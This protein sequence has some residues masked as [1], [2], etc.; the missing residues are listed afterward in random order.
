MM[1]EKMRAALTRQTPAIRDFFDIRYVQRQGFDFDGIKRLIAHKI[2]ETE[3]KYTID[4]HYDALKIQRETDLKP[5]LGQKYPDF[6]FDQIYNFVLSFK[7]NSTYPGH[8]NRI[9]KAIRPS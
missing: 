4:D 2:A 1:A 9:K 7:K 5:V 8:P 6:D 3:G